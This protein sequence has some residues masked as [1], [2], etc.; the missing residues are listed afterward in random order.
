VSDPVSDRANDP[1]SDRTNDRSGAVSTEPDAEKPVLLRVVKGDP[2]PE[3]VAALVAVVQGMAAPVV[4]PP[5]R[6]RS[7][8][9][10][11][12]RKVRASFAAGPGGWRSSGMPR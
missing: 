1:V 3:E 7:E 2:T 8:W 12:H 9:S 10:A 4:P 11:A 5:K 6:P